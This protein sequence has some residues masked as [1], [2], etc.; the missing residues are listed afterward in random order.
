MRLESNMR[1]APACCMLALTTAVTA[2]MADSLLLQ[3][4]LI[5]ALRNR[6]SGYFP[7][8]RPRYFR[9]ALRFA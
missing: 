3:T 7:T 2:A 5:A 9:A 8:P 4:N 6:S 1:L